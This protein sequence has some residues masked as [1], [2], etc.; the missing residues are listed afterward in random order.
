MNITVRCVVEIVISTSKRAQAENLARGVLSRQGFTV[1]ESSIV[2]G[3]VEDGGICDPDAP[4]RDYAAGKPTG[5][6]EGCGHYLCLEC[7]N[8]EAPTKE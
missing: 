7:V 1:I 5:M 8:R 6:C 2:D 3:S 4:C